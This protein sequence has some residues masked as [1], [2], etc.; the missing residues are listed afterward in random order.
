MSDSIKHPG[1]YVP[2]ERES[3]PPELV[4]ESRG[5]PDGAPTGE[6]GGARVAGERFRRTTRA[7]RVPIAARRSGGYW[8][9]FAGTVTYV[10]VVGGLADYVEPEAR[11]LAHLAFWSLILL[12]F[13]TTVVRERRHGWERGR[14]WPFAAGALGGAV[15]VEGLLL[16]VG[17]STIIVGSVILL[18][19]T[20]FVLMLAG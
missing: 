17:S 2:P 10:M 8:R 4:P 11:A 20:L 14:R 13:L 9:L 15:A 16:L 12:S 1:G 3:E 5:E 18:G 6:P 19:M 7:R